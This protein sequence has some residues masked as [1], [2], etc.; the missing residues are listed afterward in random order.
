MTEATTILT[1]AAPKDG[2]DATTSTQQPPQRIA[3]PIR[4]PDSPRSTAQPGRDEA[5]QLEKLREL[6]D[7]GLVSPDEYERKRK[8]IIDRM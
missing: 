2:P 4:Q 5:V 3:T 7:K 8:E 6:R 1:R